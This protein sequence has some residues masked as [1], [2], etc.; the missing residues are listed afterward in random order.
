MI[1]AFDLLAADY[2]D[3]HHDAVAAALI[4]LAHPV[5]ADR[6][7]AD[8][9]CGT[10]A[11]AL[12]LA[13]ARSSEDPAVLAVDVSAAMVAAGRA[14]A[15]CSAPPGAIDWRVADAVPLPC[16]DGAL[17][18]ILCASSL[19][20]LGRRALADWRRALRP[21]GRVGYT[22]PLA[23]GFRP[24]GP[25]ASLVAPDLPLPRTAEDAAALAVAAGFPDPLVRVT[26]IGGRSV[27]LTVAGT[28]G[29]AG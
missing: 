4:G 7:V 1:R 20:F 23:P 11:V 26:R 16:A 8:V 2:D 29:A 21:G 27:A 22:L 25:F 28:P 3:V 24:S 19:H 10:G 12:A 5:P 9:A 17:D 13:R 6:R 14:R 15:G 18:L